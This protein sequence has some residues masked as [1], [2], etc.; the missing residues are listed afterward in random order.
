MKKILY[1]VICCALVLPLLAS[2]ESK[3]VAADE[4]GTLIAHMHRHYE[5]VTRIQ[6]AVIRGDMAAIRQPA[7]WLAV[8]PAPVDAPESWNGYIDRMRAA[9]NEA[10]NAT[11][12]KTAA[13]AASNMGAACGSCHAANDVSG[14][15]P[16]LDEPG[17]EVDVMKHMMRHQWAADRMWEGLVGPSDEAWRQGTELLMEAALTPDD[18]HRDD[19]SKHSLRNLGRRVHGLASDASIKQSGAAR[20]PIY[21]EF[22]ASCAACH[23]R[24]K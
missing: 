5:L 11:D 17:D 13:L 20:A 21:A 3:P 1:P 2:T 6:S 8:H 24:V 14:L 18:M 22:L 4:P 10:G 23:T 15:F 19:D 16:I 7:R 9:A 12:L